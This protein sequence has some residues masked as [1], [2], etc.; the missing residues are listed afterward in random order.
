VNVFGGG[1]LGAGGRRMKGGRQ[2]EPEHDPQRLLMRTV[3]GWR[4]WGEW[5]REALTAMLACAA[6]R[7]YAAPLC[8]FGRPFGGG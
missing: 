3:T 1:S 8:P 5:Q 7:T 6:G 4:D 2:V